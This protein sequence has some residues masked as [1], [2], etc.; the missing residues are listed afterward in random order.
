MFSLAGRPR[1]MRLSLNGRRPRC[2]VAW[3]AVERFPVLDRCIGPEPVPADP[4]HTEP[5]P[6]PEPAYRPPAWLADIMDPGPAHRSRV[7]G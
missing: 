2:P 5:Q 4:P 3:D 7:E 1:F 6:E